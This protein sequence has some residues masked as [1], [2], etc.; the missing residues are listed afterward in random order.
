MIFARLLILDIH[1]KPIRV[2]IGGK[3]KIRVLFFCKGKAK[4]IGGRRLWVR[5]AHRWEIPVW[6]LLLLY[7]ENLGKAKLL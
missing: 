5:V 2:G 4:L 3:D 6:Q 7:H 1:A